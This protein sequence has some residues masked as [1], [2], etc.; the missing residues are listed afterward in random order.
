MSPEVRVV[1][2][3]KKRS[4]FKKGE[5]GDSARRKASKIPKFPCGAQ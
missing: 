2:V 4:M 1:V 5:K 3:Q